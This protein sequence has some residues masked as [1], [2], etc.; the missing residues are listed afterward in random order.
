[1]KIENKLVLV[2]RDDEIYI[3][4]PLDKVS[5]NLYKKLSKIFGSPVGRTETFINDRPKNTGGSILWEHD[6]GEKF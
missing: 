4:H 6:F 1:M 3:A 2:W 5:I